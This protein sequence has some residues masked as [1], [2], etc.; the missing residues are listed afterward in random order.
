MNR[1]GY[2]L[3]ELI[4][5]VVVIGILMVI[6][7]PNIAGILQKN[8]KD[9]AVETVDKIVANAK[10]KFQVNNISISSA[11]GCIL[12]HLSYIDNN[13]DFTE[14]PN[15][16]KFD[17]EKSF[18]VIKKEAISSTSNTYKYYIHLVENKDDESY[19][20][21]FVD[22]DEYVKSPS[23]FTPN[24]IEYELGDADEVHSVPKYSSYNSLINKYA[25]TTLCEITY[26]V[27]K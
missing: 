19:A 24:P 12:M 23:E 22:Y 26:N 8:K 15:G 6:T 3:V 21:Q 11:N 18:V 20:L 4:A 16:G 7:I 25:G 2:T 1:K 17:T 14:G 9:M 27:Y 10:N 13:D 5:M